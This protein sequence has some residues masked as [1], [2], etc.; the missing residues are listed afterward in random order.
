MSVLRK[1]VEQKKERLVS[2][3]SKRPLRTLRSLLKDTDTPRAFTSAVKRGSENI[4]FIAEIKKA[5]PSQGIIRQ[6]FDHIEIAVIYEDRKVD[7]VSVL[8][9][10]D[11]FQG[12]IDFLPA[13]KRTV[14]TPVLR[15]DFIIDEYQIFEA[16]AYHADA[17]LLIAALLDLHQA[18][19]YR[20]LAEELGMT[21]IFEIHNHKEL[22]TGL[23][24][25]APV[26]GI[27]NRDLT[28]LRTDIS[29]T[30]RLKKELP[31]DCI[32]ISESGI[33]NRDDVI[34]LEQSGVDAILVGTCLM[35]SPDI[36]KKIDS[37]RGVD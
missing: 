9:E 14:T 10:E 21:A 26:I 28:T 29:T 8:T 33:R 3:K 36:G 18:E 15:K 37:L 23:A 7:A 17:V 32:V 27:N 35:E 31:Q 12:R 13:V 20:A 1:I 6:H 19:E 11:F 22:E 24:I 4:R 34:M 16:R 5:S 30:L 25:Q 2:A